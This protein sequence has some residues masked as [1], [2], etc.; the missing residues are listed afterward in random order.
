MSLESNLKYY[1]PS[2]TILYDTIPYMVFD[3]VFENSY[4]ELEDMFIN[5]NSYSLKR[6]EF[7]VENSYYGGV[8]KYNDYCHDI[9]SVVQVLNLFID[10]NNFSQYRTAPNFALFEYFSKA[11]IMNGNKKITYDFDDPLGE[12][13]Y[14]VNFAWRTLKTH[15]GQCVSMPL[16]YKILCDELGG[17]SALAFAPMHCYIKHI[18]EDGQWVNVEITIVECLIIKG[19]SFNDSPY[20]MFGDKTP[21]IDVKHDD[22]SPSKWTLIVAITD[23][24][25]AKAELNNDTLIITD[26]F[27]K[28][29]STSLFNHIKFAMFTSVDPKVD[30]M[31]WV[32][33]YVFCFGDPINFIDQDGERPSPYEAALM[34]SAVYKDVNNYNDRINKLQNLNWNISTRD[35]NIQKNHNA[36]TGIGMQSMIFERSTNSGIEYAYVYAGT[37]SWEDVVEDVTQIVGLT[38]QYSKAI[39]NAKKLDEL[40]GKEELTFVGHSLGGGEAAAASMATGRSAITFNP[41]ALSPVTR[42][43]NGISHNG[44]IVNYISSTP[45]V[46]GMNITVD[47]ITRIQNCIGLYA[48]GKNIQIPIG[49]LPSHSIDAIV[50]FFNP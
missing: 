25:C 35:F 44:D 28:R 5:E 42:L 49:Y 32:S 9:D 10:V 41:A 48:P 30:E 38:S 22:Y 19:Q 16:L 34:A 37:N 47:F 31:P 7:L 15:K 14:S 4:R 43:F 6:A 36:Q 17:H 11:S 45:S 24:I 40:V 2:E 33:P 21:V 8:L 13:D 20:S 29:L 3:T 1:N 26:E 46:L 18:G 39:E 50:N 23:S 27:C 12:K